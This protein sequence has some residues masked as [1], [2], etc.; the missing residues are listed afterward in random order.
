MHGV[1]DPA[2]QQLVV[3]DADA[4]SDIEESPGRGGDV[5]EAL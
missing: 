1:T 5:V 4:S 3:K 2:F